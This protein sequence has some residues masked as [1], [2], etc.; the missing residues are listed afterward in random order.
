MTRCLLS[1]THLAINTMGEVNPCCRYSPLHNNRLYLGEKTI[2]DTFNDPYLVSIRENL[3]NGIR[4]EGCHHCWNEEDNGAT[5]MRQFH[6]SVL[7]HQIITG[8]PIN[9][10]TS[11]EIAF[12]NHCNMKCRHC[13]TA[14]SSRWKQDDIMLGNWVPDRIL[15]EPDILTIDFESLKSVERIKILGG[16]PILSKSF[17]KFIHMLDKSNLIQNIHIELITNGS[18]F[19]SESVLNSLSKAKKLNI[20]VSAD[21]IHEQFNY[22]RTDGDFND[23][24]SN[25]KKYEMLELNNVEFAIHTVINVLN[26]YRV[27]DIYS[28][29]TSY[30][31]KWFLFFDKIHSPEYLKIEQWSKSEINH[32]IEKLK[33]IECLDQNCYDTVNRLLSILQSVS[34]EDADFSKLFKTNDL[35]DKA[36]NTNLLETHPIFKKYR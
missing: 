9:D 26:V 4:D 36:R 16:E 10:I 25:M 8:D 2:T 11:I 35:L 1:E 15:Q 33:E 31:P 12:S 34:N 28:Y 5:S 32:Q 17:P 30:F 27:F 20:I 22:F 7:Q 24:I 6:N 14:S 29:F 18:V 3:K 19:P 13:K 23:I 21:D